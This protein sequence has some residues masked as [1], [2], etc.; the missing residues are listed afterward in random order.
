MSDLA[1]GNTDRKVAELGFELDHRAAEI[2][3]LF[4]MLSCVALAGKGPE[5]V[6]KV[7]QQV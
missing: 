4:T 6:R 7:Q 2:L 5:G 3:Y 1:Q